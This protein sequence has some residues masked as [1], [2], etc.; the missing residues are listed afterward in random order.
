MGKKVDPKTEAWISQAVLLMLLI[1]F[2]YAYF[3]SRCFIWINW[4]K[5]ILTNSHNHHGYVLM[6]LIPIGHLL[7]YIINKFKIVESLHLRFH[8]ETNE[9][10]KMRMYY[11][12]IYIAF[13]AIFM[14]LVTANEEYLHSFISHY[15]KDE[16][17]DV[18]HEA[19]GQSE[20]FQSILKHKN[21]FLKENKKAE[22]SFA[23][24]INKSQASNSSN[25]E[26]LERQ[27]RKIPNP[28][29]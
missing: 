25:L 13:T 21:E 10:K 29:V 15:N 24:I 3:N 17:E 28:S 11:L 16:S 14:F 6:I 4:N 27:F 7:N 19:K 18:Q 20:T 12:Y 8:L 5:V 2:F 23:P 26:T 9:Q 1:D 22:H